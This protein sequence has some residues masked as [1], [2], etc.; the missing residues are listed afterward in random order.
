MEIR[1]VG[2]MSPGDMGQ[3]VAAQIK[4][5]GL[6][7]V[8]ALDGRSERSRALARAAGL[9][10]V[11]TLER[12]VA[13]CDVILSIMNPAAAE[14]FA[15]TAAMAI[16]Q[17]A[18]KPLFVDCNA[19]SPATVQ[20]MAR[21]IAAAGGTLVDGGII[22]PP[23]RGTAKPRLYVSGQ[24]AA[25]LTAL[26]TPQLIVR[27]V[28]ERV[29][30]AS[31]LKMCYGAMTKGATAL[32]LELLIAARHLGVEEALERELLDT[33][34]EVYEWIIGALP[35]M[36][37]KAYRWVPEMEQEAATFAE[38][39]MTPRILQGAADMYAFVADTPLG[40]ETPENRD[41]SRT[42]RDVVRQLA[43]AL[44]KA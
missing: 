43:A 15:G 31:A 34:R 22:G 23:P 16:A 39:G 5:K 18:R 36:P 30:E 8:A 19:V 1:C 14:D 13:E 10:D 11:G 26:E 4:S 32:A 25:R 9:E 33:R 38:I 12:M 20:A 44:K 42:G 6:R 37:P 35:V 17:S 2:V 3:A 27:V 29:G 28:G 40:R 21:E 24:D 41:R 7:V